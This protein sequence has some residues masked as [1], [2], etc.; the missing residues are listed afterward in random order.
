MFGVDRDV[1]RRRLRLLVQPKDEAPAPVI[2]P[3]VQRPRISEV[4]D[5]DPQPFAVPIPRPARSS[6]G[7]ET[8]CWTALVFTDTHVP[9]QDDAALQVAY[10]LIRDVRPKVIVHLGDLLDCYALSRY[11]KDRTH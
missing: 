4:I 10:G 7:H 5:L 9:Y 1:I 3:L 8:K 2:R 6:L 11:T